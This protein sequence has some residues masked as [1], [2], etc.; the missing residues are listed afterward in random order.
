MANLST[1][2][3]GPSSVSHRASLSSNFAPQLS[4]SPHTAA[5]SPYG[6]TSSAVLAIND[7]VR[8]AAQSIRALD[9]MAFS[10]DEIDALFN[11]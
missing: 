2:V 7:G 9:S 4:Q 5:G 3:A 11:L 8:P 6:V 1:D 10:L